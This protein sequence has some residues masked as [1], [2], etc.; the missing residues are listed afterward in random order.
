MKAIIL[1][2]IACLVALPPAI[3]QPIIIPINQNQS[4][5]QV[6]DQRVN[7]RGGGRGRR[8]QDARFGQSVNQT[9]VVEV[10]IPENFNG[11]VIVGPRRR[12]RRRQGQ[13]GRRRQGRGRQASRRQGRGFR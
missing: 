7:S 5:V 13:G 11:N 9:Q 1:S 3:A 10:N 8:R 6:G 2:A 4:A 12:G